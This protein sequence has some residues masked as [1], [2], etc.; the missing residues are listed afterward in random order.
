MLVKMLCMNILVYNNKQSN[1]P[2][3]SLLEVLVGY[4]KDKFRNSL[5]IG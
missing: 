3:E 4:L 1:K 5:K 2:L